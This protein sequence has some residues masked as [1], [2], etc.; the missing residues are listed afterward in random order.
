[1]GLVERLKATTV[2]DAVRE[3]LDMAALSTSEGPSVEPESVALLTFHSAKGLEFDR[4][5]VVGVEDNE[6]PGWNA[7]RADDVKEARRLLYVALT[8]ARDK[9]TLTYCRQ[10]NGRQTGGTSFLGEM[11]LVK[12]NPSPITGVRAVAP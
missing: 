6:L 11:G 2:E 4:L 12:A 3:L 10:R 8:R 7:T 5:Y 9:L 1:M